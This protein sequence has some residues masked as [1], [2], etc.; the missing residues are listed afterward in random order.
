MS[1]PVLVG[2]SN[3][4]PYRTVNPLRYGTYSV[5]SMRADP[6]QYREYPS[7]NLRDPPEQESPETPPSQKA[8]AEKQDKLTVR[9]P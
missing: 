8:A 1:L 7:A 9:V 3:E 2:I 5:L 4:V 6:V